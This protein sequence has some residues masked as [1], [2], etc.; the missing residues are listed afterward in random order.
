[1]AD[2]A[3]LVGVAL[4]YEA[5]LS[6][7]HVSVDLLPLQSPLPEKPEVRLGDITPCEAA[8]F[9]PEAANRSSL[10]HVGSIILTLPVALP[11]LLA[12]AVWLE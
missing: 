12:Q 7:E 4:E 11:L 9:P 8:A 3:W 1:M 10:H 6:K 5:T 2:W